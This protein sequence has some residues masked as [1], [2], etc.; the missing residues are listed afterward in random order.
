MSFWHP[1]GGGLCILF[2]LLA[3]NE[4]PRLRLISENHLFLEEFDTS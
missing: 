2:Q 3:V 4:A 1:F